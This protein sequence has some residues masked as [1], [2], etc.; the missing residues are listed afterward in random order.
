MVRSCISCGKTSQRIIRHRCM[1]CYG[2]ARRLGEIQTRP[3]KTRALKERFWALVNKNGPVIRP[4]LSK[5]WIW[6]G[7]PNKWGY[8]VFAVNRRS[9][10]VAHR[11][12]WTLTH[13]AIP[14]ELS[15]LHKCDNRLCVR[16][17][18]LFIGTKARQCSRHEVKGPSGARKSSRWRKVDGEHRS[19]DPR[20][21]KRSSGRVSKRPHGSLA[22][23]RTRSSSWSDARHG[24]TSS[25]PLIIG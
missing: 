13:G 25:N 19:P 3:T 18:H 24:S 4:G 8:G 23:I 17:D 11:V 7:Q 5:C 14:H 16:P 9:R 2:R 1:T 10:T 12:A 15:A 22:C 6:S 21:R 20:Q